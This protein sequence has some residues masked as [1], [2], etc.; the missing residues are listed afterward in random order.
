MALLKSARARLMS[1]SLQDRAA[2]SLSSTD[3]GSSLTVSSVSRRR[4]QV[5]RSCFS[6]QFQDVLRSFRHRYPDL[7]GS[8]CSRRGRSRPA[9]VSSA[10]SAARR[11]SGIRRAARTQSPRTNLEE[12]PELLLGE[13]AQGEEGHHRI[14][15][16]ELNPGG[17]TWPQ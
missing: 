16:R 3:A 5:S 11:T 4:P 17:F 2:A 6:G 15:P 10:G 1:F 7:P 14:L 13:A 8:P 9:A 12:L